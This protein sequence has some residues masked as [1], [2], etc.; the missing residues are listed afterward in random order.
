MEKQRYEARLLS[1]DGQQ[2]QLVLDAYSVISPEGRT[3]GFW[4]CPETG[5]LPPGTPFVESILAVDSESD[6]DM[7]QEIERRAR[8]H[9]RTTR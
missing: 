7:W 9:G 2:Y 6:E 8:V 4:R 5:K 3:F 1:V